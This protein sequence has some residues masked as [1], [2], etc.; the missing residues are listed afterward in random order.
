M[1]AALSD[2]DPS[3]VRQ[4]AEHFPDRHTLAS[5][6]LDYFANRVKPSYL[7]PSRSIFSSDSIVS[8][9]PSRLGLMRRA[10]R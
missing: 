7:R 5:L 4:Q 3:I 6:S 10:R 9:M 2:L 1:A 8:R